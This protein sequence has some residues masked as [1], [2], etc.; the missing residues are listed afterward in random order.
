MDVGFSWKLHDRDTLSRWCSTTQACSRRTRPNGTVAMKRSSFSLRR[1]QACRPHSR[2]VS[3]RLRRHAGA[4]MRV[5]ACP[6]TPQLT[7]A[8]RS[9]EPRSLQLLSAENSSLQQF[10]ADF[11]SQGRWFESSAA[12]RRT[13]AHP[14]RAEGYAGC[15]SASRSRTLRSMARLRLA[16]VAFARLRRVRWMA[17]KPRQQLA[18]LHPSR[19]SRPGTARVVAP[20]AKPSR[21]TST[22]APIRCR[23]DFFSAPPL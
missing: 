15:N 9:L 4:R 3:C 2:R 20:S 21:I 11:Y 1:L 7:A 14:G 8:R 13:A 19:L 18:W 22:A 16:L 10:R 17:G 6:R 12:H 23:S 5:R